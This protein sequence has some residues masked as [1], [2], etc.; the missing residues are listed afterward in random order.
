MTCAD[1]GLPELRTPR[2]RYC[3]PCSKKRQAASRKKWAQSPQG[4]HRLKLAR[5]TP[6]FYER[7]SKYRAANPDKVK[8][9]RQKHQVTRRRIVEVP[10]ATLL[11]ESK[12]YRYGKR[13]AVK[14]CLECAR[15]HYGTAYAK[16]RA[17]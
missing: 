17:A 8:L 7:M 10:C 14:F 2:S 9:W 1:C 11:C 12:V 6:H 5:S 3:L 13:T 16:S 15:T 4:R